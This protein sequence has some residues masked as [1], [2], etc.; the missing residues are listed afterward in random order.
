MQMA[1]SLNVEKWGWDFSTLSG[2]ATK[3]EKEFSPWVMNGLAGV[4]K[5]NSTM[6]GEATNGGIFF[7]HNC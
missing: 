4:V 7:Y 6:S 2:E 3:V 1:Q 5:K